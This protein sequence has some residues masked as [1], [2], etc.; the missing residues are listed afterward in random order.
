VNWNGTSICGSVEKA[1]DILNLSGNHR[2]TAGSNGRLQHIYHR[3]VRK[4][5]YRSKEKAEK[6][7]SHMGKRPGFVLQAYECPDCKGWHIGN[8]LKDKVGS[9]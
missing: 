1:S 2:E 8:I 9:S 3:C 7:I 4:T 6:A 5:C